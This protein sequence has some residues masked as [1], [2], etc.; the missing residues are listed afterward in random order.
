MATYICDYSLPEGNRKQKRH[1]LISC[2]L[3]ECAGSGTGDDASRY[4]Y[5]V[6]KYGDYGIF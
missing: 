1:A 3:N 4:Q 6:E 2:F 5:N